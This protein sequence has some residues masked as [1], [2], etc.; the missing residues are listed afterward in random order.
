[1]SLLQRLRPRLVPPSHRAT[2]A[3]LQA[4]YP[5]LAAGGLGVPGVYIGRDLYGSAFVYDPFTCYAT[6]LIGSPNMVV[7]GQL[8][9]RKSSLVKTYLWRQLVFGRRAWVVDVKGEYEPLVRAAGGEPLRLHPGGRLRLNPLDPGAGDADGRDVRHRQLLLVAALCE[10]ALER[11]LSPGEH[12]A[13]GEALHALTETT[14]TLPQVVARLLD[15]DAEAAKR[16]GTTSARMAEESRDAALALR[17]LVTGDLA[18]MFD[19]P[20]SAG[21]RLDDRVVSLDVSALETSTAIGM[22][23]TCAT[24][25]LQ[26]QLSA[27]DGTKRIVVLDEAWKVLGHLGIARWLRASWKLARAYGVQYVAVMH[28]LSDLDAAGAADSE[29]VRLVRGL[30]SDVETRVLYNQPAAE[31]EAAQRLLGLSDT[32][33]RMLPALPKGR[34]LWR[35]GT[36]AFVVDHRLGPAEQAIVDTDAAITEI[37]K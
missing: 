14:P 20:T 27:R 29:Q 21:L 17:R 30:L 6:G 8:G 28:R 23:M 26:A 11:P 12:A 32:E 25:F 22:V 5:C 19:G 24:A 15:P 35:I 10:G 33:T 9:Y 1:M 36:K 7:L 31:A 3:N 18:G 37:Q 4:V 13:C 34:A 2:T 16:V